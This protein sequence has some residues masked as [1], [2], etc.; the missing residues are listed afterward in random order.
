MSKTVT[1]RLDDE[2]FATFEQLARAERRPVSEVIEEAAL[3]SVKGGYFVDDEEMAEIL[4]DKKLIE[5][6][7]EGLADARAGR[8]TT[9]K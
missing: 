6:I 5:G 4:A 2:T 9:V 7:E 3:A 1:L 8:V